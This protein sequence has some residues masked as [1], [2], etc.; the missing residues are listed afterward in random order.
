MR[1]RQ[2]PV[3]LRPAFAG[4]D[5]IPIFDIEGRTLNVYVF[6][7]KRILDPGRVNSPTQVIVHTP[8]GIR[9]KF[10]DYASPEEAEGFGMA[11]DIEVLDDHPDLQIREDGVEVRVDV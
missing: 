3:V 7:D 4:A 8:P 10:V 2:R 1:W 9:A 6:A 11:W 5:E